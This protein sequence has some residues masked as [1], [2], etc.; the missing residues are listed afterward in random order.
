[1][2]TSGTATLLLAV[3]GLGLLRPWF[4]HLLEAPFIRARILARVKAVRERT[5][6][7]RGIAGGVMIATAPAIAVDAVEPLQRITLAWL[8]GVC[9]FVEDDDAAVIC[10]CG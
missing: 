8:A 2:Q 9:T 6:L 1:M 5:P 10:T 4:G 3:V 7:G